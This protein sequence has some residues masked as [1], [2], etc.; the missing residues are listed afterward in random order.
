M[1]STSRTTLPA[2]ASSTCLDRP[3]Q[4]AKPDTA[5]ARLR[6]VAAALSCGKL[7]AKEDRAW[8]V[9]GVHRYQLDHPGSSGK[10]LEL[11]LGLARH[12]RNNWRT[13][14]AR[15]RRNAL[16]RQLRRRHFAQLD[17]GRAAKRI[18]AL[19]ED[20][21]AALRRQQPVPVPHPDSAEA[22]LQAARRAARVPAAK[23]LKAIL[24]KS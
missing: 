21:E 2:T 3:P 4:P 10:P 6:R 9:K 8:F 19:A 15:D 17:D 23:Q 22:L 18:A 1:A 14:E 11:A 20:H 16:I 5:I 13:L 7:P 24:R 12:G